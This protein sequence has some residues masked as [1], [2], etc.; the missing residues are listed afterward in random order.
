MG[1][2]S[3]SIVHRIHLVFLLTL[4]SR[5][6]NS[7]T[8]VRIT[9]KWPSLAWG[10]S[11]RI[12]APCE[13]GPRTRAQ[14][15][16]RIQRVPW[17]SCGVK[18]IL[19][20]FL[21]KVHIIEWKMPRHSLISSPP[22]WL[23]LNFSYPHTNHIPKLGYQ[24]GE[25]I[26]FRPYSECICFRFWRVYES[27]WTNLTPCGLT[28]PRKKHKIN[29]LLSGKIILK[30][31]PEFLRP[32]EHVWHM[33]LPPDPNTHAFYLHMWV[34]IAFINVFGASVGTGNGVQLHRKHV[35]IYT[36]LPSWAIWDLVSWAHCFS[37]S[38]RGMG[39]LWLQS[40][41]FYNVLEFEFE[42]ANGI[43]LASSA[44]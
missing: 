38:G 19:F 3:L 24:R 29:W 26:K 34:P 5:L 35:H 17:H 14:R 27:D 28:R 21:P 32:L 42:F 18:F 8:R 13:S 30:V 41:Q 36:F 43:R 22:G 16:R 20:E 11:T 31:R 37:L 9:A 25:V 1:T 23:G 2:N 33:R 7:A 4:C 12:L 39:C 10:N 6:A 15:T 44:M 40:S